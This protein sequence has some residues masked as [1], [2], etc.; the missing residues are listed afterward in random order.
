MNDYRWDD[1]RIGLSAH[2]FVQLTDGQI[3]RFIRDTGD[4]NPLHVDPEYA[5]SRGFKD[6]VAHG[7]LTSSF[8]S[9]LAGVYL[10]GRLC[11]LHGIDVTLLAPAFAGDELNVA[12]EITYLNEAY[13]QAWISAHITNQCGTRIS[14]ARIKAGVYD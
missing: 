13:R 5:R 9:T 11:L 2:F 10:P 6:A 4:C 14:R 3:D 1:L 7:L 8:Y 12:G